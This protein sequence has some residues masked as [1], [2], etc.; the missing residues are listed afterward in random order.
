MKIKMLLL[1]AL[2]FSSPAMA[3]F[4]GEEGNIECPTTPRSETASPHLMRE[5]QRLPETLRTGRLVMPS[6]QADLRRQMQRQFQ[7]RYTNLMVEALM[8]HDT[9]FT[10]DEEQVVPGMIRQYV[11]PSDLHEV[12]FS[13]GDDGKT[14]SSKFAN[15]A[16]VMK[17][18]FLPGADQGMQEYLRGA[19]FVLAGNLLAK[20][21]HES[22]S[23]AVQLDIVLSSGQYYAWAAHH[24]P[25]QATKNYYH[26]RSLTFLKAAQIKA[27]IDDQ[28]KEGQEDL[29]YLT[30]KIDSELKKV[31]ERIK[32]KET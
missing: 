15:L 12:N 1:N 5:A 4:P 20:T 9:T 2:V 23:L 3:V 21:L 14:T 25:A 31:E 8:H 7:E 22:Q 26:A 24:F 10:K 18:A 32:K 13:A 27:E 19:C 17:D 28:E 29:K 6:Q 16:F 11:L 30:R